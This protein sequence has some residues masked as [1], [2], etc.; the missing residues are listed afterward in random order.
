FD[1]VIV[2]TVGVGQ[3]EVAVAGMVDFFLVLMVTGTG[4]AL[5]G[6]KKGILELADAVAIN[7]ADGTNR[8]AAERMRGELAG[9]MH[10]MLPTTATWTPPV[11]TC[12]AA[13]QTGLDEIWSLIE[14]HRRRL[15]ST[16]ELQALRQEQALAW[17]W[18]MIESGLKER[19]QGHSGVQ[20]QLPRWT[21]AV[22][23]GRATPATAARELLFLLDNKTIIDKG[24]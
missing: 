20:A 22:R 14:D 7:K 15:S 5:Q 9:A 23:S 4:D 18:R 24:T 21:A 11:V 3:S 8:E 1:V 16:G 13:E 10:L 6:I 2:E 19:F 17:M 12:S